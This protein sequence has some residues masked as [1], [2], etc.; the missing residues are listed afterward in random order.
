M[1]SRAYTSGIMGVDGFEITVECSAWDRVP[2]F[3]LVGLPDA[4]VKESN[5]R[6][7]AA[8]LNTGYLEDL[9]KNTL[10]SQSISS[11]SPMRTLPFSSKSRTRQ[12]TTACNAARFSL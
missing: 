10:P 1:L 3:E 5:E 12:C 8:L 11:V 4:A 2:K 9:S 7:R 6:I